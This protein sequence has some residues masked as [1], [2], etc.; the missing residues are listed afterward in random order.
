LLSSV[1]AGA[2]TAIESAAVLSD[3]LSRAD[4]R[5]LSGALKLYEKRR[6]KQVARLQNGSRTM[7]R[8]AT[9]RRV[10]LAALR[11]TT[12]RMMPEGM[13]LKDVEESLERPI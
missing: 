3:E 5:H 7:F 9:T 11:D 1:G 6:R 10:I 12:F 2:A 4:A 8:I 13:L